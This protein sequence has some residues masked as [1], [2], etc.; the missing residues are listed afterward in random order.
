MGALVLII[1]DEALFARN[2]KTYLE[3]RGH[4]VEVIDGVTRG[5]KRYNEAQPDALLID[6]NLPDGTGLGLIRE[7]RKRDRWT[8]LVMMT[9]HGGVDIA[10]AAMKNGADDY[11]TKPVSLDEIAV[12]IDKLVSQSRLEGSLS[13]LRSRE[14]RES[15]LDRIIGESRA[16]SDMKHRIRA[17]LGAERAA[18]P[19]G[20][21]PG[22]PVLIL[23]ETGTGKE[24]IARA[25]HFDG[26]RANQPFIAINCSALPEQLVESELFGHERGAF[27]GASDKKIGLFQAADGGTLFLDEVG[28][29]PL[30]QQAKLLKAIE[31][32][33]IRPVGSVRD[34]SINVRFIAATNA[35]LEERSRQGEFRSDLL[36][37]LNTITIDVPALRQRGDDIIR[38]AESFITQCERRYGR[39]RLNLTS[40]AR[41]A[42][43]RHSWPGN[44]RELRNV[45]EQACLM[46][47]RDTIEAAD[48]NLREL[49]PLVP[50]ASAAAAP[51]GQTNDG[52]QSAQAD[53][54]ADAAS[55][56]DVERTLIIDSLRQQK[57]NV[58][59]AARKLGVSRD[60]LRYR[61][62]KY[63]LNREDYR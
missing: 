22:P 63:E 11:L 25:L 43:V 35:A 20:V 18:H 60:T 29:L 49:R 37:R 56:A 54:K 10:V 44:V 2:I 52:A 4:E 51:P 59:L 9:A 6:H 28:E 38:L 24:L 15:G 40:C 45:V 21:E 1:E 26:P 7:I 61:M 47:P 19:D 33:S 27:T 8:K 48:L 17:L 36:Y 55:L 57:G 39:A 32:Q 13:Y 34:R 23:G 12:V 14:K 16:I 31:D 5:L 62:D 3:R 30:A 50:E 46:C 41:S 42:L 58:T 53:A